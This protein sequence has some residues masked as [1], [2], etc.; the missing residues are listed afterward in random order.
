MY[1]SLYFAMDLLLDAGEVGAL[2]FGLFV[3]PREEL[4]RFFRRSDES[5]EVCL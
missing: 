1:S 4:M 3:T 5:T 2:F